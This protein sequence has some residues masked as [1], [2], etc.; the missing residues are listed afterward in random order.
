MTGTYLTD[1]AGRKALCL[2][3]CVSMTIMLFIVGGLTKG[4]I[5]SSLLFTS[6]NTRSF[7]AYGNGGSNGNSSGVYGT[8]ASIFLFQ[9]AYSV[10]V[11]PLTILY[12]PEVLNYSIR[13]NGMAAWT[14]IINLAG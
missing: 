12:P 7:A 6:T 9:G 8:V 11:T 1:H 14:L 2:F 5:P 10:G 4:K 3:A 13:S